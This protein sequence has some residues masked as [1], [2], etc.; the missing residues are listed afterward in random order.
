MGWNPLKTVQKN[1][2]SFGNWWEERVAQPIGAFVPDPV[3]E[4]TRAFGVG[5]AA[6]VPGPAG[7]GARREVA[8]VASLT[9]QHPNLAIRGLSLFRPPASNTELAIDWSLLGAFGAAKGAK[10]AMTW[11]GRL[12]GRTVGKTAG[13]EAMATTV[14]RIQPYPYRPISNF[15]GAGHPVA[16]PKFG[17]GVLLGLGGGLLLGAGGGK[18]AGEQLGAAGGGFLENLLGGA[19]KG[20]GVALNATLMPI[21]VIAI[22]GVLIFALAGKKGRR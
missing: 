16:A 5:V 11:L 14:T 8:Q 1:L 2:G 15:T 7:A 9:D 21:V 13:K 22:V 10:P 20:A 19:G 4:G 12:F 17:R 3:Q 18:N 6:W